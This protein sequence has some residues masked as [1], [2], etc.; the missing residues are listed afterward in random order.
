[1]QHGRQHGIVPLL[2]AYLD[3]DPPCLV[4]E[5]VEGGDL[6]GMIRELHTQP[7]R[8]PATA[9]RVIVRLAE[10]IAG[11]HRANP[12]IVHDDLKPSNVLIRRAADGIHLY[13]TD[14]GIGGLAV[15]RAVRQ[16]RQPTNSREQLLTEAVRGAYTPL[17]ASLEQMTRRRDE[18]PDPRDD[19]HALGMIW[20]QLVTGELTMLRLP[21]D[22]TDELRGR[23]LSE[24]LIRLLGTCLAKAE[25]RPASAGILAG[26]LRT[27]TSPVVPP[28][29]PPPP[30]PPGG[31]R[32][33]KRVQEAP[34][35]RNE[36]KPLVPGHWRL[37]AAL[38]VAV[39]IL[40]V[41][42]LVWLPGLFHGSGRQGKSS[43]TNSIGMEFTSIE[44][45]TFQMGSPDSDKDA[46]DDEK[47]Q[48]KVEISNGYYLG[49]YPVTRGQFAQFV[50]E[51]DFKTD[52]E[53]KG[54]QETWRNPGFTGYTQTDD[55]PVV[56]VS[57]NDAKAFCD[58]LS[59]KEGKTYELPREAEWEYAC[60]AGTP[61][62]YYFGDDPKALG[63][64]AWFS[65]NSDHH[66]HPV[67][68]KKANPWGLCDMGGNVWQWCSD[69]YGKYQERYIKDPID[70]ESGESRVLR[71]GSWHFNPWVCRS[72]FR[73]NYAP[74]NRYGNFGFRVVLRSAPRTP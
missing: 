1:M 68:Q 67:G 64:Y 41:L 4:Y 38:A 20:Y 69:R 3:T 72:A 46:S 45:G 61:T 7:G 29:P 43:F 56:E 54:D 50:K 59:E 60:R 6:T 24:G 52:A 73:Y 48:H 16:T 15:A 13:V 62:I 70:A 71:G 23:G 53:K 12:A 26:E 55:D 19:V 35:R 9:N 30:S 39:L 21:A 40:G 63:N 58:W 28:P 44:P 34:Q 37:W 51:A 66:T 36:Q 5:Y 74:A 22:W 57:W 65:D 42:G 14:Y 31:E 8:T 25:K 18:P 47:P 11:A 32:S 27:L 17:Y 33:A 2:D 10:I 49:T